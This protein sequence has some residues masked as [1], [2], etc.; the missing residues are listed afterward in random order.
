MVEEV[1]V[2]AKIP[3]TIPFTD[4]SFNIVISEHKK[5]KNDNAQYTYNY[6]S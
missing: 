5:I 3:V 6:D 2:L 4:I 1:A